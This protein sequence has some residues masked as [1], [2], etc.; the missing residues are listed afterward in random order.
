M[1]QLVNESFEVGDLQSVLQPTLTVDEYQSRSGR[2]DRMCVLTFKL[3]DPVA[4][5]DLVDF[6]QRGYEFIEDAESTQSSA[7]QGHWLVF[8]EIRRLSTLYQ[9]IAQIL[10]DLQASS[11]IK[12]QHWRFRYMKK[13]QLLPFTAE[14]FAQT[15]P[16]TSR[17]YRQ[18]Q[19]QLA[20]LDQ[21]RKAAGLRR[22][23]AV[24]GNSETQQ[25]QILAG[26]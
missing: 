25:L 22:S 14:H 2:D 4:A 26:M 5:T 6:L 24:R 10:E 1:Q 20:E 7:N 15:V 16:L 23:G 11:G 17:A 8:A 12:P 9:N 13:P 21:L 3:T 18:R 19:Q